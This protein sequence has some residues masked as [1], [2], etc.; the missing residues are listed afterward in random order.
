MRSPRASRSHKRSRPLLIRARALRARCTAAPS[1]ATRT[2]SSIE[3][4][5]APSSTVSAMPC[6]VARLL[7]RKRLPGLVS[8]AADRVFHL[9][10]DRVRAGADVL[11]QRDPHRRR[12]VLLRVE[13]LGLLHRGLRLRPQYL[14]RFVGDYRSHI[15][16]VDPILRP[17]L[18]PGDIESRPDPLARPV[19]GFLQ[20][21]RIF[22]G[23][24]ELEIADD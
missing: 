20:R 1:R 13:R 23:A 17:V 22:L 2:T 12:N 11:L 21:P 9:N 7:D 4:A 18:E 3:S 19:G 5:P 24:E 14:A 16:D 10:R 15:A 6:R 8:L